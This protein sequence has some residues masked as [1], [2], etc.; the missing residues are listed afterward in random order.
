M[1]PLMTLNAGCATVQTSAIC[2]AT[3]NSRDDLTVALLDDGGPKS[4]QA[5]ANLIGQIDAGCGQ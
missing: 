2:D 4:M 3:A 1:L 5:G